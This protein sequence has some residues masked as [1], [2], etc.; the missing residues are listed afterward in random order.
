M[1]IIYNT[2]NS[3]VQINRIYNDYDLAYIGER[4]SESFKEW[5]YHFYHNMGREIQRKS[6]K[7]N[8]EKV[9]SI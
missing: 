4:F 7:H 8:Q 5:N 2:R 6:T 3:E 1:T 9:G